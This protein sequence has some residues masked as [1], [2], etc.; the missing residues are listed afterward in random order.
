MTSL[1]RG[2]DDNSALLGNPTSNHRVRLLA[3]FGGVLAPEQMFRRFNCLTRSGVQA[4]QPRHRR[5]K[6]VI[7]SAAGNRADLRHLDVVLI[8]RQ[9]IRHRK[10]LLAFL[11]ATESSALWDRREGS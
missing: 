2:I 6:A 5:L 10:I 7:S 4:L 9:G 1:A 11:S 3:R 8:N